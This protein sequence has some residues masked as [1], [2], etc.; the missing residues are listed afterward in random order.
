MSN[1][2]ENVNN[3]PISVKSAYVYK[4][5][6]A[7][8]MSITRT[9]VYGCAAMHPAEED[10]MFSFGGYFSYNTGGTQD[11]FRFSSKDGETTVLR[12]LPN[13]AYGYLIT[14]T[15]FV[16][17]D[18]TPAILLVG[19]SGKK[20]VF[21]YNIVSDFYVAKVELPEHSSRNDIVWHL[22]YF[23]YFAASK[24]IFKI[25]AEFTQDWEEI[26]QD[27]NFGGNIHYMKVIPYF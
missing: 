8:L 26:G 4:K 3:M 6:Q 15:D 20:S 25:N 24:K 1:T 17:S 19:G 11:A 10:V 7:S 23:Y 27:P 16:K 12:E 5:G 22:G 9:A 18:G 14:C 21:E 2:H 13:L